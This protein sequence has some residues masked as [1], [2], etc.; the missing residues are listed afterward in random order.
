MTSAKPNEPKYINSN[1]VFVSHD[2]LMQD[3]VK[4]M[5][6]LGISSL[7]VLDDKD[8][9]AG[10]ITERDIVR[11]FTLLEMSDKL[12][13]TV[14]TVMTRPV[15][16][17]ALK[18]F[19]K[20]CVKMH[21]DHKV[22]HFPVLSGPEPTKENVVGIVSI[23]DLARHFIALEQGR[24][25]KE[26]KPDN[27]ARPII[28]VLA[29]QVAL[30][31]NYIHIFKNMGFDAREVLDIHQFAMASDAGDRTL[32]FDLDGFSDRDTHDLIPVAVKS[33]CQL[34][35]T[36]SQ[37]KL[38]PIFKKYIDQEHQNI[39]MKPIDISYLSWLLMRKWQ[40]REAP[41]SK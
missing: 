15:M 39:A 25:I 10:I 40:V 27:A 21:L 33:K 17:A 37:S 8:Q 20:D 22:R 36:T 34:V 13:R 9:V 29:S 2:T 5:I 11:K 6:D 14:S 4:Q 1:V 32:I 28:G 41:V 18:T 35:L 12:T 31:N 19:H 3:A 7:L 38:V 24:G 26:N 30:T 16:F 23:T